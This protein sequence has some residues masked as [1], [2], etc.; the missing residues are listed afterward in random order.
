MASYYVKH[1]YIHNIE[2][3]ID[4]I[5]YRS[6][7]DTA[8]SEIESGENLGHPSPNPHPYKLCSIEQQQKK[9]A[10]EL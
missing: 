7:L 9:F 1:V 2:V 4:F 6:R 5:V 8:K 10:R 3:L